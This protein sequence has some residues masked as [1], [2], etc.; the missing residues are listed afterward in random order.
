MTEYLINQ[1]RNWKA[2]TFP[3]DYFIPDETQECQ[4]CLTQKQAEILRGII[5]PLGWKTRWWSN[6]DTPINTDEIQA[7]RDDII[8][9]LMMSCCADEIPVQ[10]RYTDGVL[11]RSTDGGA[12]WTPAPEFDPRNNSTQFPPPSGDEPADDKRCVAATG[13][14]VLMKEQIRDQLT[15]DMSRFTLSEL[16]TTWLQTLIGT[17]NPFIALITIAVNQIFALVMA[18]LIPALTDEVFETLKCIFFC[19]MDDEISFNLGQ[20][21]QVTTDIGDQIGGIATLFFQQLIN[22]LGE[23]GMTNLARAGGATEGDCSTCP[24]ND[25]WCFDGNFE[26]DSYDSIF[27]GLDVSGGQNYNT[28]W[29]D[30]IGWQTTNGGVNYS[31][32]VWLMDDIPGLRYLKFTMTDNADVTV[33]G[34][35]DT[36]HGTFTENYQN[37][38]IGLSWDGSATNPYHMYGKRS[39][40]IISAFHAEGVGANPFGS[41]NCDPDIIDPP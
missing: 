40:A 2:E 39:S 27:S 19:N 21:D 34:R 29:A 31:V 23:D 1:R 26:T 5:E 14:V 3:Y 12:T 10:F 20:I 9:R 32:L 11:E 37:P 30:G 24:C 16:I 13:M 4:Y 8:R 35:G 17:S 25:F 28:V 36:L 41:N 18:V 7:F 15:D 22:L 38:D 33:D 6:I